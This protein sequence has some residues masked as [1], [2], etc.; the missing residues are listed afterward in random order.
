MNLLKLTKAS[1]KFY[2]GILVEEFMSYRKR[3]LL[4]RI[5]SSLTF[6]LFLAT[7]FTFN[8]PLIDFAFS[9][10]NT[11]LIRGIFGISLIACIKMT[12]MEF[13]Y[14][15]YYFTET[16]EDFQVARI[17]LG[18]RGRDL[19]EKLLN[20]PIGE[21]IIL[22]LGIGMKE[23]KS[24][25]RER[26]P[27]SEY[28]VVA[29][30]GV[31]NISEL[32][33]SIYENDP[34][35]QSFLFQRGIGA[36]TF[37][38]A[39][40][41]VSYNQILLR[42]SERWWTKKH[43]RTIPSLGKNWAYGRVYNVE[44]Y[45]TELLVSKDQDFQRIEKIYTKEID[46]LEQILSKGR[47]A[48]ALFVSDDASLG[49]IL[50]RAI[51]QKIQNGTISPRLE[52]KRLFLFNGQ[53]FI[54]A[55]GREGD[56]EREFGSM[57][58]QAALA[59]NIVIVIERFAAFVEEAHDRG[60]DVLQSLEPMLDS[61]L[62]VIAL[63]DTHAY[64]K[65]LE[66]QR[67][68][69]NYFE[70]IV[71]DPVETEDILRLAQYEVFRLEIQNGLFFTYPSLITLAQAVDR[72]YAGESQTDK[73]LDLLSE[74]VP[75]AKDRGIHVIRKEDMLEFLEQKTNIPQ[76]EP[77]KEERAMLQNI[78]NILHKRVIGQDEAI[79]SIGRTLRRTR[80]QVAT[81]KR[82][83]GSFLFVGPTGVGKT[84]TSKALTEIIA[85]NEENLIRFDMSEFAGADGLDRLIGSSDK[86]G[87]LASAA[88]DKKYGVLLIDEFEKAHEGVQNLF[89]QILDEGFF[90]DGRG[91]RVNLRNMIIIATS[92]AG[93]DL[94]YEE[95]SVGEVQ[96]FDKDR[97]V[98]HIIAQDIFRPEL[99]NRFDDVVVFH[100]LN[101]D[102]LK[103][104]AEL[105]IAG[106]NK[107]LE[108]K[109]LKVKQTEALVNYL[110]E[111]GKSSEFGAR[112]LRRAIEEYVESAIADALI[113]GT[114]HS[115]QEI[116]LAPDES[117]N[118]LKVISSI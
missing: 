96:S 56:F 70:R 30:D 82:P 22:R 90:T 93:S 40:N 60:F 6:L 89:L 110:A 50:I 19:T 33:I 111:K 79:D 97:I 59:G 87:L 26:Q 92:N 2:S 117:G 65:V 24:F 38:G 81:S 18:K 52:D 68:V 84:E 37:Y 109:G 44:K 3:R 112:E 29:E 32:V 76:A 102:Q 13:M 95:M 51:K 83:L 106:L 7:I 39:A 53:N 113:A 98:D 62:L 108:E 45:A 36:S 100:P 75:F 99:I 14:R 105:K 5:F 9:E 115:G 35:F 116:E 114:I 103:K 21:Y 43:L 23:I 77:D 20:S 8:L 54:E 15:S 118:S 48:N 107:R 94:M 4:R 78:E 27:I 86:D 42:E 55:L 31:I 34:S 69:M 10:K 11:L 16:E 67:M 91:S 46:A 57:L 74:I 17:V 104:I 73:A 88:R 63:A 71:A 25:I 1:E 28:D 64:H 72:I 101:Q 85:G 47:Q 66:P 80:A 12:L 49:E 41:W 58:T 61:P